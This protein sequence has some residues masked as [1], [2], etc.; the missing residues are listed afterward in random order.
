M[1]EYVDWGREA[2]DI[3]IE[4]LVTARE[5]LGAPFAA[6][7]RAIKSCKGKVIVTG[8]GKS[9][10]IGKKIAATLAS[11]GTPSFFMHS[12]EALHGDSG[13][14]EGRDIFIA[15]SYSGA[16]A[17]VSAVAGLAKELGLRIISMTKSCATPLGKLSDICLEIA[18]SK[19]ADPLGLAPTASSTLT[20]AL[21]DALA[22]AVSRAKGFKKS[23]F[24]L[25]HPQ[26]ALGEKAKQK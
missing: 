16:T 4:A 9:G 10:H 13:M 19:E 1:G 22:V 2:F 23:D 11:L 5:K 18:V 15:I 26:G 7:V 21:G 25:R 6:A 3:E 14:I 17:E 24:A 20:L 8:I 12:T